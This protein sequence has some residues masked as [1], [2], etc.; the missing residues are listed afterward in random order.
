MGGLREE[1]FGGTWKGV[2][3]EGDERGRDED[4]SE[5]GSMAEK[6]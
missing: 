1:M 6:K 5:A 3:N 4:G 2:E